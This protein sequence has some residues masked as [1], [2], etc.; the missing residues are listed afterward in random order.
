MFVRRLLPFLL[1]GCGNDSSHAGGGDP[2]P[3]V[4]AVDAP[5]DA[6][7]DTRWDGSAS[8]VAR[9]VAADVAA[10]PPAPDEGLS[11][12]CPN[13]LCEPGEN[14]QTCPLDCLCPVS[15]TCEAGVCTLQPECDGFCD[16]DLACE[17]FLDCRLTACGDGCCDPGLENSCSCPADCAGACC[18]DGVCRCP[19]ESFA[20]CPGDC[21]L[22]CGDGCCAD[23][24]ETCASCPADCCP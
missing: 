15:H 16:P 23:P 13:N 21:M 1:V 3:D 10:E 24:I 4:A 12:T 6:A 8:D 19:P 11:G 14:C 17:C 9:D 20:N 7:R 18:G 22:A 5:H 2:A